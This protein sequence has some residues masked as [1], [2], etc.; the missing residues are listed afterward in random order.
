M[1][2]TDKLN[3]LDTKFADI[4]ALR[5]KVIEESTDIGNVL[6]QYYAQRKAASPEIL[7]KNV[8]SISSFL[9]NFSRMMQNLNTKLSSITEDINKIKSNLDAINAAAISIK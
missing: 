4:K 7:V 5:E 1:S 8:K 3:F 2:D 9:E 6:K